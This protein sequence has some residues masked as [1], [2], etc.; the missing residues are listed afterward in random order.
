VFVASESE[1]H[2]TPPLG[3]FSHL[4]LGYASQSPEEIREG[5][6]LLMSAIKAAHRTRR[7]AG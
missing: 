6:G 1:F 7:K 3:G 4:R 5:M 2:L